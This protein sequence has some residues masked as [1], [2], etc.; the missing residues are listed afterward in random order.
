MWIVTRSVKSV[1]K[2]GDAVITLQNN[3]GEILH[4]FHTDCSE[5]ESFTLEP[6]KYGIHLDSDL[7][8]GRYDFVVRK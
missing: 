3:E 4:T 5:K 8:R 1:V 7:F 6:G 2:E